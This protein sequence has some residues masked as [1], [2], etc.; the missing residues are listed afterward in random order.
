[1]TLVQRG[2]LMDVAMSGGDFSLLGD[3]IENTGLTREIEAL[4]TDVIIRLLAT[5]GEWDG[6]PSVGAGISEL[7]GSPV[8]QRSLARVYR[9]IQQ[10]LTMDVRIPTAD[11]ELRIEQVDMTAFKI[12]VSVVVEGD[13]V[14]LV[15]DFTFDFQAGLRGVGMSFSD[16]PQ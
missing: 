11:L 8:T 5:P 16:M 15:P 7:V 13:L 9:Q 3:K 12:Q 14:D 2:G 4:R 1:M 10:A 6:N